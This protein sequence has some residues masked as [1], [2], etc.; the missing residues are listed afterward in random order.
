MI[1]D[2]TLAAASAPSVRAADGGFALVEQLLRDRAGVLA[3]IRAGHDLP[4]LVR[5]AALV[6]IVG[7]ALYGAAVG[8]FRGG[9]QVAYAAVKLPLVLLV[10][11]GLCAPT[12]TAVGRA[13]GRPASLARDLAL[14]MTALAFG[15][16]TLVAL[17]PVVLVARALE[18]SYH[19]SILLAVATAAVAGAVSIGVLAAGVRATEHRDALATVAVVVCVFALVGAQVAW[20]LRPYL[21][22]PRTPTAPLVRA[23]DGSLYDAV[24]GSWRSAQGDYSREQAP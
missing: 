20:T 9:A 4:A 22:R 8:S 21:V 19:G 23:L 18:V 17:G 5:T 16:L 14:V 2:G 13:L 7:A 24:L 1:A 3:R 6:I 15:G 10:T 11:A 12:L